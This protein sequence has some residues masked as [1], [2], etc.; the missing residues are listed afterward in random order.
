MHYLEIETDMKVSDVEVSISSFHN[1]ELNVR[2]LE[3]VRGMDTIIIQ[4]FT[5]PGS[6][7]HEEIFETLLIEDTVVRS[8]SKSITLCLPF[9]PY[10]RQDRKAEGREPISAKVLLDIFEHTGA[11]KLGRIITYDMH[12]SAEQGFINLPID[13]LPAMPVFIKYFKSKPWFD[14]NTTVV[15]T[16]DVGSAKRAEEFS[17]ALGLR[18]SIAIVNKTRKKGEMAQAKT[19]IGDIYNKNIIMIDDMIDSGGTIIAAANLCREKGAKSISI[20]AT[21]GI[22]SKDAVKN[23]TESD[24]D[25]VVTD[26]IPRDINFRKENKWL[27]I[28]PLAEYTAEAIYHN[29]RGNS[30]SQAIEKM[31]I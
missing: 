27:T 15:V 20:A 11:N 13:N 10:L 24:I 2:L 1:G 12:N 17:T 9:I 16:P 21:H 26:S 7:L 30:V 8:F 28:I 5:Q 3:S 6:Q 23:F 4:Q 14:V 29:I 19:I 31:F 18:N 25:V 22:F